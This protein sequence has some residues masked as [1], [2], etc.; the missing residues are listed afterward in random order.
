MDPILESKLLATRRHL[1]GTMAGGIGALAMR[2]LSASDAPPVQA[3][4]PM[5]PKKPPLAAKAKRMIV[6][7]SRD[8]RRT[9]TFTT[10]S[11]SS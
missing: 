5:A 7:T 4:D 9:S 3:F 1:L 2:E 11:R 8:R 10:T 6:I